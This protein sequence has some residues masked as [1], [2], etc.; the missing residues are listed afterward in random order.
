MARLRVVP[1][2]GLALVISLIGQS[3]AIAAPLTLHFTFSSPTTPATAVGFVTF[4]SSAIN[5]PGNSNF[6]LPN[7]AVLD[8]QV[9]VSGATAGNGTFGLS[10]FTSIFLDT[11]GGTLDFSRQLIGQATANNPFGTTDGCA[12]GGPLGNTGGD[13]N[14]FALGGAPRPTGEWFFTLV[15]NAGAA[16]CMV[17][18]SL[19][20]STIAAVPTLSEWGLVALAAL[21]GGAAVFSLRR[22]DLAA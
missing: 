19:S 4:E 10:D 5:N 11:G 12:L 3:L 15:A 7:P 22:R 17:L 20:T 13:F 9:V 14:M 18:T 16:D 1:A 6:I 2:F 21:L 8:L